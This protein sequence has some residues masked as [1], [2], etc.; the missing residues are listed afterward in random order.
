MLPPKLPIPEEGLC[1]LFMTLL[2][3]ALEAAAQAEEK[4]RFIHLRT[5]IRN[6]FLAVFCEN[7]YNGRL[8][9][10]PSGRLH[11]TKPEAEAHGFGLT[12]MES[13]AE[14]YKSILD[15][16]YTDKVFPSRLP[17]NSQKKHK[18]SQNSGEVSRTSPLF[19]SFLF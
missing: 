4:N 7:S 17:S 18:N 12:L 19:Y 5:H 11:S 16:S 8:S 1:T 10:D 9:T 15:V 13:V 14:K 6:G 3:N 2:D